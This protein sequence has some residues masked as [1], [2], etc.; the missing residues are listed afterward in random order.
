MAWGKKTYTHGINALKQVQIYETD[1]KLPR[2][3]RKQGE[4]PLTPAP[5]TKRAKIARSLWG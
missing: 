1:Q 2:A 4:F 3:L 5:K